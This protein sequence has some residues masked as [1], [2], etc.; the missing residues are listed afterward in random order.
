MHAFAVIPLGNERDVCSGKGV[1]MPSR[2]KM[3]DLCIVE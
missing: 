1:H 3:N 2:M